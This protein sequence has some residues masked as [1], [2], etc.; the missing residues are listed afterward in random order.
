MKDFWTKMTRRRA[1]KVGAGIGAGLAFGKLPALGRTVAELIS[2]PIPSSG[3]IIPVVGIGTAG[4]FNLRSVDPDWAVRKEVLTQLPELGGR[5]IDTAP[6]YGRGVAEPVIGQLVSE[7]GNREKL[8]LATKVRKESTEEGIREMEQS[9]VNL[10]TD[11]IDLMQIHNLMNWRGILP[12]VREWKAAGRF[13]YVGMTTSSDRQ[14]EAFG[15]MM[16]EVDLDFVQV[17]Y[18]LASR[19]VEDRILPLAADRG[20]A[21]LVNLPYGRGRLFEAVGDR[22]LP[23][24]AIELGC[25]SWGQVFLKYIVSHP[26][27][28]CAIPGTYK[29]AYLTDNLGAATGE[30][31]DA[32][33]RKRMED[34]YDSL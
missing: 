28:T 10:Q 34:F 26:A 33:M 8:F 25:E 21:V 30:M 3:E 20:M 7:I 6:S 12:Y 24:W 18:S 5:L 16:A 27:I 15:D 1:I 19:A 4:N 17:N 9:F 32:A 23:D 29:M 2:K 31:P 22:A 11:V 13:R 14:H